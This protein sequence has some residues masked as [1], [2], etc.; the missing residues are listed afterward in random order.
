M[1]ENLVVLFDAMRHLPR[2]EAIMCPGAGC[3]HGDVLLASDV[4]LA[5]GGKEK[6]EGLQMTVVGLIRDGEESVRSKHYL[7][8]A[9][10]G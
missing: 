2:K 1:L 3:W 6:M 5:L 7:Y 9:S 4:L 10:T 8:D